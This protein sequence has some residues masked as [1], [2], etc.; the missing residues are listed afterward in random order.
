M[1]AQKPVSL[2]PSGCNMGVKERILYN[3]GIDT[4]LDEEDARRV[5]RFLKHKGVQAIAVCT[6]FSFI[7]PAHE[8]RI[9]ELIEEEFPEAYT[10]ISSDL[11]SLNSENTAG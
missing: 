10:T 9:K 11:G 2:I 8:R 5:I 6:L 3:G 1:Q 7:N 4:P